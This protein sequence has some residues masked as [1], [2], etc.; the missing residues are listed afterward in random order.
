MIIMQ[1]SRLGLDAGV[2]R[3]ACLYLVQREVLAYKKERR[4]LHRLR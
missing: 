2:V 1:V 4:V 3:R